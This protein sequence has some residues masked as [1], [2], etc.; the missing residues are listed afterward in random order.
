MS[1]LNDIKRTVRAAGAPATVA[2]TVAMFVTYL[3]AWVTKSS[4]FFTGLAFT[5]NVG[6]PWTFLTYPFA[7]TGAGKDFIWLLVILWWFWSFGVAVERDMQTRRYTAFFFASALV[8]SLVV[9]VGGLFL[10]GSMLLAGALIPVSAVTIIWCAVYPNDTIMLFA[11]V[12]LTGKWLAVITA[13]LVLFELGS[14]NPVLGLI[15]LLP[16]AAAW[17]VA[18]NTIPFF[19]YSGRLA[20]RTAEKKRDSIK[21]AAFEN[22]VKNRRQERE[23]RERL[24][25][26]FENSLDDGDSKDE[27]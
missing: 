8:G 20:D 2:L 13:G 9:F 11:I 17:A 27:R 10:R 5:G 24:R 25:R 21:A 22:E 15:G 7:S 18:K 6:R 4:F 16:L 26:L 14:V 12:P 3:V 23:E 19:P 1:Y